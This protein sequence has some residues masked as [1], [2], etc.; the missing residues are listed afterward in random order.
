MTVGHQY[1][2][3]LAAN[4]RVQAPVPRLTRDVGLRKSKDKGVYGMNRKI[5]SILILAVSFVFSH[6]LTLAASPNDSVLVLSVPAGLNVYIVPTREL[7]GAAIDVVKLTSPKFL[8]GK[9]PLKTS[10]AAGEYKVSITGDNI[11]NDF[12]ADGEEQVIE[13]LNATGTGF[14]R[15]GKVYHLIKKGNQRSLVTALFW[16][17]KQPIEGFM[18]DLPSIK[19]FKIG[20]AKDITATFQ[21][22]SIPK[23]QW[24]HLLQMLEKTG[25]AVWF[26][27]NGTRHL[28]LYFT[29]SREDGTPTRLII[30]PAE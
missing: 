4:M 25:K 8:A 3:G 26:H 13:E 16:S 19:L 5:I 28:F 6:S 20:E 9:T 18:E 11:P 30:D 17:R 15:T 2:L 24:D 21:K 14:V 7:T 10:L 29:E 22:R 12:R 1:S 23:L 27:S